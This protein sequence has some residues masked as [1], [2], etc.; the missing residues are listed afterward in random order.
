[1]RDKIIITN[2]DNRFADVANQVAKIFGE[3]VDKTVHAA[4]A[5]YFSDHY[6]VFTVSTKSGGLIVI[7]A[8]DTRVAAK[9]I[10]SGE[11]PEDYP[12]YLNDLSTMRALCADVG[13]PDYN[14]LDADYGLDKNY[15]WA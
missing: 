10:A 15:A 9:F 1:M 14:D 8:N 13:I 11:L 12:L 3:T 7:S 4:G 2:I 6:S 5:E